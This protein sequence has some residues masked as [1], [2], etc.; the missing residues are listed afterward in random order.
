MPYFQEYVMKKEMAKKKAVAKK[1]AMK[2]VKKVA[3][4]AMKAGKKAC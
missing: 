1:K 4:G 3:K 2:S